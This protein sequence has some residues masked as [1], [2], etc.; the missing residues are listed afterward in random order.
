MATIIKSP[1]GLRNTQEIAFQFEDVTDRAQ[2]QL[3]QVRLQ[4]EQILSQARSQADGIRAQAEVEGKQAAMD[5]MEAIL[6]ERVGKQMATLT[7]ALEK[8]VQQLEESQGA[9]LQHWEQ[10]ALKVAI[11]IAE[12]ILQREV[13]QN[14]EVTLNLISEAIERVAGASG[15]RILLSTTD[16]HNLGTHVEKLVETSSRLAKAEVISSDE[17]EVGG[18]RI[19]S[20][21]GSVDASFDAQLKR[22]EEELNG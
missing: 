12:R 11:A 15:V 2:E 20:Q 1:S 16:Y 10:S 18:C 14:P 8:V 5:A 13:V 9:L 7:P 22:I 21:F 6:E 3:Q 19:E 17:V 4:C